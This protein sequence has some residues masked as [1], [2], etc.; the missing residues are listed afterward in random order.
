[1]SSH[2]TVKTEELKADIV[3]IG[4]G[5]AGLTAAIAAAEAG[6]KSV[7]VLEKTPNPGGNASISHGIFAAGSP[8]QKRLGIHVSA[9]EVFQ[10]E[11]EE[12]RGRINPRL[13]RAFINKSGDMLQWLEDKGLKF[14]HII[15]LGGIEAFEGGGGAPKVFHMFN[16]ELDSDKAIGRRLV[17]T[18]TKGCQDLGVR[19]LCETAARKIL[20]DEKGKVNGVLAA[21]KGKTLKITTKSVIIA[22]GGFGGNKD[23]LNKY[24][25]S[26]GDIFCNS[27]PQVTGDGLIMAEEVGAI[28]ENEVGIILIGPHHYPWARSL[29]LLLRR[30]H[31]MLVNKN[32]ER[33]IGS[34]RSGGSNALSRQPGKVCYA[35]L[36]ADLLRDTIQKREVLSTAE[37]DMGDNGTW[38]DELENDLQKESAE[39]KAKI[40]DTWDE[41][42]E[43]IG[44]KPEVLKATV[45]RYNSF[46][47]KGYDEDF[48]KDKEFLLPLRTPPYYAILG[49]QGFDSTLGGIMINHH[50]E[51]ISKQDSPIGGLYAVGDN[52][53]GWVS[54]D[55]TPRYPGFALAFALYSGYIAG[56][57]AS[58]YVKSIGKYLFKNIDITARRCHNDIQPIQKGRDK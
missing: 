45:E 55:Y 52:A 9:D 23:M 25:P 39:G 13:V 56:K 18:L 46:C 31:M 36:D 6:A 53:G 17:E 24:F 12:S 54:R 14:E 44:A 30:P 49:R 28:I 29:N 33:Y 3:V 35:L 50:M 47:D 27:V 42:A 19:L 2:G 8:A 48:L 11:M 4:G 20:T 5:G 10:D 58:E 37:K 38:I 40:A 22:A 21:T 26:H 7:I 41:I 15:T 51:V 16:A 57:N 1:M 32:G 43:Y 34:G